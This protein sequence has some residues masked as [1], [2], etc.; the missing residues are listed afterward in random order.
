MKYCHGVL[1]SQILKTGPSAAEVE[2]SR[3]HCSAA[4]FIFASP[5]FLSD[6]L[7]ELGLNQPVLLRFYDVR[8]MV[9]HP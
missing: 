4:D 7:P 2:L 1:L 5:P 3:S 6:Y 8:I 9:S